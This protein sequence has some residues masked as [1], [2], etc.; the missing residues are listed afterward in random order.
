MTKRLFHFI[1]KVLPLVLALALVVQLMPQAQ[2][3]TAS[4][5]IKAYN[6]P[7][8]LSVKSSYSVRGVVT[9]TTKLTS[10]TVGVYSASGGRK[11]G[12]TVC[13]RS[14]SYNIYLLRNYVK[15]STLKKGTYYY[16]ITCS[17]SQV[18]NKVILNKKFTVK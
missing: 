9:S 5:K 3:A 8:K 6:Y 2:A 17:T 1:S 12:R 11:T 10:L 18:K 4:I 13:P 15:F 7:V 16:R 14:K